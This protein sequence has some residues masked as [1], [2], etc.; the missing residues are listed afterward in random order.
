MRP[1]R[2]RNLCR[3]FLPAIMMAL[4]AGPVFAL[5]LARAQQDGMLIAQ[6][7]THGSRGNWVAAEAMVANADPLVRDVVLWRKLRSREGS[8]AEYHG[9]VA[10]RA[11]WP[12]LDVLKSVV[13]G[14]SDRATGVFSTN[15]ANRSREA[16]RESG[17]GPAYAI[18]SNHGMTPS[19]GYAYSDAEWMAGWIALT[20][21]GDPARALGHFQRF[22]DSVETPISIGRGGYW[23]GRAYE[24][25][26]QESEARRWY[27]DAGR[28]QTT[29]YG[30]LAAERIGMG[31]DSQLTLSDLPDWRNHPVME[32][33]EV[34]LAAAL[35]FAGESS[36]AQQTF[37]HLAEKLPAGALAPLSHLA[38]DLGEFH[39]AV[40]VAKTAAG[41]GV[42]IYPAYYPMHGLASYASKI[43]PALALSIARQETEMN[44]R[45]ISHAGARGLM[46]LMPATAKKVAGW[47]GEPYDE[48]RLLS[49]WQYNV[50]LGETYLAR[51]A[52][53]YGGSYVMAAAAYN[54]GASR[55]DRWAAN[56]GDPRSPHVDVI[57]WIE[58]IPFEETRNYVQRVIEGLYV[59]RTRIS[60][61]AGPMTISQDLTRGR[62]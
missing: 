36:L 14:S 5:D 16:L 28:F 17:P 58:M 40:R 19:S 37:H 10:R 62:G 35:H 13:L 39:Y 55:V 59:Y 50:R 52:A 34:R 44:P 12:G 32:S 33:D 3:L 47:I 27:A 26:G 48:G 42:L 2:S 8:V 9:L 25:A 38:L 54:A 30:Q 21:L 24:A 60:G 6:A 53:Q 46:Q 18:A 41:R 51:R 57:D 43:E 15:A 1:I 11:N 49:D 29:F 56:F 31:G 20:R 23:L 61:K 22:R 45:A 7:L 4:L